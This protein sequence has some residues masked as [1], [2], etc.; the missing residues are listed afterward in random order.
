MSSLIEIYWKMGAFLIAASLIVHYA[1]ILPFL[2]KR[3]KIGP[4]SWLFNLRHGNDLKIYGELCSKEGKPLFW[5]NFLSS[6][7][8]ILLAWL[9]GWLV[10]MLLIA[11]YE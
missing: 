5:Y 11:V 6:A 3:G 4:G 7:Q 2:Q 10:L 9:L 1:V 8:K